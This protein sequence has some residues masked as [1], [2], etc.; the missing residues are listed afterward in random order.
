MP[1]RKK[2]T[3]ESLR[4]VY[5]PIPTALDGTVSVDWTVSNT[6]KFNETPLH[7]YVVMGS[8]GEFSSLTSE[9]KVKLMVLVKVC[10]AFLAVF[11]QQQKL[12][13]GV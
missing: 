4:G 3:A 6:K 2:L 11:K 5:A 8:N 12:I 9:E 10:R 13:I 7:G 1:A